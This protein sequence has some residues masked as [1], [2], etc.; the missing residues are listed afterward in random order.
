MAELRVLVRELQLQVERLSLAVRN[1]EAERR[2]SSQAA[3][4]ERWDRVTSPPRTTRSS[5][6]P[7]GTPSS[8]YNFLAQEIPPCPDF[9]YRI[10]G[11][12]RGSETDNR[13]RAVR[14][15]EIGFW[16]RFVLAGQ[17]QKPRPSP[18]AITGLA[19]T[20]YVILRA[21][22]WECPL[23]CNRG[24][25]YRHILGDFTSE[26]LSHGFAS[27]AE[28]KIYCHGAGV[29]FPQRKFQWSA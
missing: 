21:P 13:A 8:C 29:E 4:S 5:R 6:S 15:W 27:L 17:I 28:A 10:A 12:L 2:P 9:C 3:S 22:G 23:T 18:P 16:A 11:G 14:A 7:L 1:L 25:D 24:S 20:I 19:N 26:T